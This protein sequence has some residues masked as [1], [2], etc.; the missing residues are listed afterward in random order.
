[1]N[2]S[3]R[4]IAFNTIL[5]LLSTLFGIL[6]IN[7][8]LIY[9]SNNNNQRQDF[10]RK[11]L[12]Y[13]EPV[14]RW[15]YPDFKN[16]ETNTN[17][18]FIVGDSYAEGAGDLFLR[19][20]YKYS[21]G[22]FLD[23]KWRKNTNIY[24]AAN[25]GSNI[26]A[27]LYLLEKHLNGD[28]KTLTGLPRKSETLNFI[29]YF[30]EGNDLE[31]TLLSK[32]LPFDFFNNKL[33]FKLP[34][35]WTV[36]RATSEAKEKLK[37][38]FPKLKQGSLSSKKILSNDICIGSICRKIPPMQTASAGLSEKEIINEINYFEDSVKKF[39][40]KYPKA[41]MCLVYIPSPATIYS[42]SKDFYYQK[43]LPNKSLKT[44]SK[45]NNKKSL[46][47]R[48]LLR[49]RFDFELMTF[50]DPTK[51]IQKEAFKRFIHGKSDPNH[52]NEHGYKLIADATSKGCSLR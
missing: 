30:Y 21:L 45:S 26:P 35:V 48:S 7:Q 3:I 41:N 2:I 1:M 50:V 13:L 15:S 23:K 8:F 14:A 49:D 32:K 4:N 52:F 18:L 17:T 36:R 22:H 44:D 46:L 24:L 37:S 25:G 39:S 27:Q 51:T 40:T 43:Y 38:K 29:L 31:D 5:V 12:K 6:T 11:L 16:S 33:R 34:I 28:T 42:P 19:N 20:S 9:I 10:P 47:I